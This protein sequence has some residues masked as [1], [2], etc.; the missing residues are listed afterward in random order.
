MSWV[1]KLA[2]IHTPNSLANRLRARRFRIFESLVSAIPRPMR[3]LD[4][5]GTNAFWE[6][7]GW[8]D[9]DDVEIT[10]LNLSPEDRQHR[11][12]IPVTGNATNLNQ[13]EAGSFDVVFS[14]S[15]IEHLFTFENQRRMADEI[16]RVGKA[17]WVQTPNF[18]FPMEPHFQVMG[19]HWMPS[20]VRVAM[21]RR[22]KCGWLGPCSDAARARELVTEVRL[23]T[24]GELRTIFP[25][26]QLIPERFGPFIKSWIVVDRFPA[27]AEQ[28]TPHQLPT[29]SSGQPENSAIPNKSA[30]AVL[31]KI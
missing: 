30:T 18:W 14:N 15:V 21:L 17:F 7:R 16:R 2:D 28:P 24:A 12:I 5:G 4:V 25:G 8:A 23:M 22:W 19:W 1:M 29:Y 3:I 9:R 10:I 11:N 26:A 6:Q 20:A 13:F 27:A 31:P